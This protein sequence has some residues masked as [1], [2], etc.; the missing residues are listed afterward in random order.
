MAG[1]LPDR[2]R[3][4]QTLAWLAR[5]EAMTASE[6]EFVAWEDRDAELSKATALLW[7]H[8]GDGGV[9]VMG[10]P[11]WHVANGHR[12]VPL[13]TRRERLRVIPDVVFR[14]Q[15]APHAHWVFELICL[16]AGAPRDHGET[17]AWDDVQFRRPEIL[18][19]G[20]VHHAVMH[21]L[22][23]PPVGRGGRPV[24]PVYEPFHREVARIVETSGSLPPRI[25][26]TR[27]M[28]DEWL[29]ENCA[30][31]PDERTVARWLRVIFEAAGNCA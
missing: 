24:H 10:R 18:R 8:A 11:A 23:N 30:L 9:Q 26:L 4:S 2:P 19:L 28:R 14:E 5:G 15:P 17:W 27:Y 16:A 6:L 22:R 13:D 25:S 21:L 12:P 7:K 1:D 20:R 3:L 31:S 29:P